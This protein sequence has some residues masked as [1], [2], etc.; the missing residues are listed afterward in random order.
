MAGRKRA[1]GEGTLRFNKERRRWEARLTI[2]VSDD[3][4]P[5]RRMV[6]ASTRAA[7]VERMRDLA[8]ATG[9]GRAPLP[10]DVTVTRFLA[11][12]LDELPGRVAPSTEQQ[13]RDV[14]RLYVI[15]HIGRRRIATLTPRDVT[16][17]VRQLEA[18]GRAPNTQRLARS[19]LRRALRWGQN[20]GAVTRNV[21]AIADGVRLGAEE[22]RTLTLDEARA[23]LDSLADD[24]LAAAFTVALSMGLRLGELLGLAW[25]DVDLE[26]TPARLTIR[27]SLK[28]LK[29]R[30]LV[31]D[32]TKTAR[33][34]RTLHVPAPAVDQLRAHRRR[35]L[36]ERLYAGDLWEPLP[37]GLDLVFRTETGTAIDPA[38]FRHRCYKATEAAGLGRWSPH[39]LR[40]SAASLLIAQGV[41]LELISELLGHQSIRITKDIYGHLVDAVRSEAADAMTTALWGDGP[42]SHG[43]PDPA[44]RR[45]LTS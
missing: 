44:R 14:A 17:M 3:G 30:G 45:P 25:A 11:A 28:R 29:G 24:R 42:A 9:E 15:P 27:R 1:N 16:Y 5:R 13:Y 21:A 10:R 33:S 23:L 31:A 32:T 22:G 7:V 6:T 39:E 8:T 20:E 18:A 35:Q 34:R 41:R 36:E 38:N 40:H 43:A 2:G 19:V 26:G 12:W 4:K 37:L